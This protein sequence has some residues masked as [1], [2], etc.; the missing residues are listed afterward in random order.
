MRSRL[1]S[2]SAV[3]LT[4]FGATLALADD[5]RYY[6]ENGITYRETRRTVLE[7][8]C[9]DGALGPWTREPPGIDD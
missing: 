2:T 9:C 4:L 1:F 7:R 3:V 8:S 6:E 5:V